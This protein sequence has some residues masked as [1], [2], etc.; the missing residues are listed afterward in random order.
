[1]A[2]RARRGDY[3]AEVDHPL[4]GAVS[5]EAA[6]GPIPAY[7]AL[8]GLDAATAIAAGRVV[9]GPAFARAYG[10]DPGDHFTFPGVAG[11]TELTVGGIWAAPDGLGRSIGLSRPEF[12][13][14]LGPRP[15]TS[16]GLVPEDGVTTAELARRVRA[17]GLGP[18]VTVLT[19]DELGERLADEYRSFAEPFRSLQ[20]G[21]LAVAFAATASTLLLV[22]VQRRREN[23]LLVAV[24]LTPRGLATMALVEVAIL[25]VVAI[26]TGAVAGLVGAFAF[27][28]ASAV[29]TGLAF[30]APITLSSLPPVAAAVLLVAGAAA[31]LPALRTSRINPAIALREE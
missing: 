29:L 16:V 10:L 25:A 15:P 30:P 12:D 18:H 27:A 2:S 3:L 19:P 14:L 8:R 23:A 26:V 9:I 31:A 4:V 17:A 22:A 1:M 11:F 5:M 20:F 6:D 24:G 7:R 28:W 21:L 13:R